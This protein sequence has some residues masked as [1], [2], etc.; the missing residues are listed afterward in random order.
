MCGAELEK[1]QGNRQSCSTEVQG[2]DRHAF[3]TWSSPVV[4]RP[5][6]SI[7]RPPFTRPVSVRR[8]EGMTTTHRFDVD[9]LWQQQEDPTHDA[10]GPQSIPRPE[11]QRRQPPTDA[12]PDLRRRVCYGRIHII[13]KY[14]SP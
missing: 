11:R 7:A 8:I 13:R 12:S 4:H 10:L 1:A 9:W 3:G 6:R 14:P 5:N 2:P